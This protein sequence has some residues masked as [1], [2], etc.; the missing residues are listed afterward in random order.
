MRHRGGLSALER[1]A[2]SKLVQLLQSRIVLRGSLVSMARV[3]GKERCRCTRGHKHVSLYLSTRVGK[4]R[5]MVY[6]PSQMEAEV[7]SWVEAYREVEALID[8]LSQAR[9]ERLLRDKERT[10]STSKR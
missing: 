2:R 8:E 6:I 7:R 4:E 1:A 9:L 3:C 10:M 5:K